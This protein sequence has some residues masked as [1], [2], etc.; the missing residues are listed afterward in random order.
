M[1]TLVLAMVLVLVAVGVA[2]LITGSG[3]PRG[4]R[5]IQRRRMRR[6]RSGQQASEGHSVVQ[7]HL[8]L[9]KQTP[10][11][12]SRTSQH[13]LPFHACLHRLPERLSAGAIPVPELEPGP[14]LAVGV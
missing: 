13:A 6:R 8:N 11:H 1:A 14:T 4:R 7:K 2:V 10:N 3:S 12:R 9:L 5:R